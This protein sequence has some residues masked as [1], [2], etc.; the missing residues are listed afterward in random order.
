VLEGGIFGYKIIIKMPD[1]EW[2]FSSKM[3]NSLTP[4]MRK[5][6]AK[7][8]RELTEVVHGYTGPCDVGA[9]RASLRERYHKR[10]EWAPFEEP[11]N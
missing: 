2:K 7:K 8:A 5:L 3:I 4:E 1:G 11:P 6:Y 10:G 9:A